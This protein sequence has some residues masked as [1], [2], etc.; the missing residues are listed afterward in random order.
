MFEWGDA[1][2][3]STPHTF[4]MRDGVMCVFDSP[5]RDHTVFSVP[6]SATDFFRDMHWVLKVRVCMCV[7]VCLREREGVCL[8]VF[9]REREGVCVCVACP[10]GRTA[11]TQHGCIM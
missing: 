5:H 2:A 7:C 11:D 10:T 4:E 3:E 1:G 6:C 8:C 9:E